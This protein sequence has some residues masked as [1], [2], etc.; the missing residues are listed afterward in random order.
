MTLE[1]L[2]QKKA[3]Y[4]EACGE[5]FGPIVNSIGPH[6]SIKVRGGE[7]ERERERVCSLIISRLS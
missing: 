5:V 4:L 3:R 2:E 7:R 6:F 1:T